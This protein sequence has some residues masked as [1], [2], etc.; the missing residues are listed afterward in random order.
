MHVYL[1]A[2]I[3][4][5]V[6][7]AKIISNILKCACACSVTQ[8]ALALP[9]IYSEIFSSAFS[10]QINN[11]NHNNNAFKCIFPYVN[12]GDRQNKCVLQFRIE[13]NRI[14]KLFS[15]KFRLFSL[16][17]FLLFVSKFFREKMNESAHSKGHFN[18]QALKYIEM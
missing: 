15:R 14:E 2:W 1:R 17:F 11:R 10:S 9:V 13:S 12:H 6:R 7:S 3:N 5:N 18:S 16:D 4:Y 8:F